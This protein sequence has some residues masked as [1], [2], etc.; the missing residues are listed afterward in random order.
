M[1]LLCGELDVRAANRSIG[2]GI[3]SLAVAGIE[4]DNINEIAMV[5][6]RVIGLIP[7]WHETKLTR[8]PMAIAAV[9]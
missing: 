5:M 6:T 2:D 8:T 7:L 3:L 4:Q 9:A 1:F